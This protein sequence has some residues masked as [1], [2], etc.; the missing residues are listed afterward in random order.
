MHVL[1]VFWLALRGWRFPVTIEGQ[2]SS[3]LH[4]LCHF[5]KLQAGLFKARTGEGWQ[6][7][8]FHGWIVFVEMNLTGSC[9]PVTC[10]ERSCPQFVVGTRNDLGTCHKHLVGALHGFSGSLF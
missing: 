4:L 8:P 7:D 10:S 9:H 6:R 2:L 1:A 3:S 5:I